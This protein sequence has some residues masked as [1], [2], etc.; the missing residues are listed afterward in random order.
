MNDT[1]KFAL[2]QAGEQFGQRE[3][4]NVELMTDIL[5]FSN[6]GVFAQM[7]VLEAL[8]TYTQKV[9]QADPAELEGMGGGFV[10][11]TTWR[12]IAQE[13]AMKLQRR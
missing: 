9:T 1:E 7:F 6:F 3:P 11:A 2:T 5:E 10:S 12:A 13:I 4:S 8:A